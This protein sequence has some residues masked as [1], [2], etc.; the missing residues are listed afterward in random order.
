MNRRVTHCG[1]V[2]G[3]LVAVLLGCSADGSNFTLYR[4]S[5]LDRQMRIHMAT[6]NATAGAAYNS[7]NC[8][9]AAE[10]FRAQPGVTAR[11]WC[12]KGDYRK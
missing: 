7:E 11:Y 9:L 6:F 4:N 10:L 1:L 12:E 2:L 3:G 8:N 5:P